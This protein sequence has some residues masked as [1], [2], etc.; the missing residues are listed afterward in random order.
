MIKRT[1]STIRMDSA[2]VAI[3]GRQHGVVT[4]SQLLKAD[5]SEDGVDYRVACGMLVPV[6]R[7]VYSVRWDP[8]PL[9]R[10]IA[11][12]LAAGA[13]SYVSHRAAA[14]VLEISGALSDAVPVEVSTRRDVRM[15]DPGIRIYRV[16]SL[17]T[18]DVTTY[19][20]IPLTTA[21]RTLFDLAATG[22]GIGQLERAYAAASRKGLLERQDLDRLL[23]RYPRRRGRRLVQALLAADE[24][25]S[26]TR[27]EAE[28]RF[29]ELVRACRLPEP[30][31]NVVVEGFE[32]D[33][34]WREER[35]IVEVDG[36]A[37]H[38][39]SRRFE[40]DRA[41]DAVLM[42]GGFRTMRV[43]WAQITR[44]PQPLIARLAQALVR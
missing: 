35:L 24:S 13:D 36:R 12:V 8:T 17:E 10:V 41:R 9:R 22:C 33:F 20:G 38:T 25:P 26:Y 27:S 34:L 1:P 44:E 28:R 42:A 19:Q 15:S 11:A 16:G 29:L 30:A 43:T 40:G 14:A 32:V 21:A 4:R 2:V 5:V 3:A 23:R 7:G 37:Y 6:H 18:H 31:T 39:A